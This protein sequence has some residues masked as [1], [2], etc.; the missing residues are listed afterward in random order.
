MR[1]NRKFWLIIKALLILL[2]TV[3]IFAIPTAEP[4]RKWLRFGMLTIFVIS[5]IMDLNRYKNTN[6]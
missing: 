1:N 3:Y 2:F 5:F 6:G 4:F